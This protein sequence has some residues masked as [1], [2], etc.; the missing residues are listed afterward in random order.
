LEKRLIELFYLLLP[1]TYTFNITGG[2]E[3][4]VITKPVTFIN[5]KRDSMRA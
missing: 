1:H 5:V 3:E 2:P 4:W